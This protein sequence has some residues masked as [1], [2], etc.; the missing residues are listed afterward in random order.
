MKPPIIKELTVGAPM[1][2]L[3]LKYVTGV[4]LSVHCA[5]C[6]VGEY[7]TRIGRHTKRLRGVRLDEAEAS[8]FYLCGVAGPGYDW[9]RNFHCAFRARAGS[10]FR[11]ESNGVVLEVEG[12]VRLRIDEVEDE[13]KYP[14]AARVA[15]GTCRNWQF[16]VAYQEHGGVP[17]AVRKRG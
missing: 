4:R 16:A 12:A 8:T 3:W 13:E 11:Y 17:P 10:S 15:F 6:L 1:R 9:E 7:S 2:Y 5:G 14:R